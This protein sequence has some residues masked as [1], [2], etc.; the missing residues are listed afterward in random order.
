MQRTEKLS[1]SPKPNHTVKS[2]YTRGLNLNMEAIVSL[3]Q[4]VLII[5][6]W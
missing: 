6:E 4:F 5:L 3:L 1:E 2:N